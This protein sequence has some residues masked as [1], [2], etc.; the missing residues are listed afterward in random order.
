MAGTRISRF[1]SLRHAGRKAGSF[2][3]K[4]T[5]TLA[6][7]SF[8]IAGQSLDWT[9]AGDHPVGKISRQTSSAV[10]GR[11][12]T[13]FAGRLFHNW[14][15]SP[16]SFALS[17]QS[18]DFAQVS[19]QSWVLLPGTFALTGRSLDW[20][21]SSYGTLWTLQSGSYVM[22]GRPLSIESQAV[23]PTAPAV[24]EGSKTYLRLCRDTRSSVGEAGDGPAT[25]VNQVGMLGKIVNWVAEGYTELQT[26][27]FRWCWLQREVILQ[28]EAGRD[29]YTPG[30]APWDSTVN[31]RISR[32]DPNNAVLFAADGSFNRIAVLTWERFRVHYPVV[33]TLPARPSACAFTPWG[34]VRFNAKPDQ[35]YTLNVGVVL[36]A[37]LLVNDDDIPDMPFEFHTYLVKLATIKYAV[38]R[39]DT[40]L[41]NMTEG[42]RKKQHRLL[43]TRCS[44]PIT[45][46]P[47]PIA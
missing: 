47:V 26:E 27:P 39:G 33:P 35:A 3:D 19:N 24:P 40:T 21:V 10:G 16:G 28:L 36:R 31:S 2:A 7:G 37:Q 46:G 45:Y 20:N 38:Q 13:S 41:Y 11:R 5:W 44:Q 8:A 22:Y 1:T 17:G 29:S 18:I 15:L 34:E 23:D 32:F 6:A 30:L 12:T 25:V 9:V 4:S 14:T 43:V 42:E